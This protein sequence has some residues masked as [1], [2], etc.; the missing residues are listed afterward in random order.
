MVNVLIKPKGFLYIIENQKTVLR[1]RIVYFLAELDVLASSRDVVARA[2]WRDTDSASLGR[3]V[4]GVVSECNGCFGV[5]P[6]LFKRRVADSDLKE[7][8]PDIPE[9]ITDPDLRAFYSNI[10]GAVK[11]RGCSDKD[12]AP[13]RGKI[14]VIIITDEELANAED[15]QDCLNGR[16]ANEATGSKL[17]FVRFPGFEGCLVR[18]VKDPISKMQVQVEERAHR[19]ILEIGIKYLRYAVHDPSNRDGD[20]VKIVNLSQMEEVKAARAKL[21]SLRCQ[22]AR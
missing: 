9:C 16:P 4:A 5:L 10:V 13:E 14:V 19:D 6:E 2:I 11:L 12:D 7:N 18:S 15:L 22:L 1:P 8:A 3:F 21:E 20:V 17:E